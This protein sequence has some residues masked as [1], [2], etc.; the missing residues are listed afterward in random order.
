MITN[1]V[2]ERGLET[3]VRS[4]DAIL[5]DLY[6]AHYVTLLRAACLLLGD[7][8]QGEKVVPEAYLRLLSRWGR[9]RREEAALPYLR[10]TVVNIARS[11][12]RRSVVARRHE[13]LPADHAPSAEGAA[14]TRNAR[15]QVITAL[16]RLPRRQRECLVL[17]YFLD[18]SE[19]EIADTLGIARGTVKAHVHRGMAALGQTLGG[20]WR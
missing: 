11:R 4:Q 20:G 13:P 15:A 6:R 1:G 12:L 19:A 5:L 10:S 2:V 3:P 14:L 18:L 7:R 8:G 16:G 9:L 17:R